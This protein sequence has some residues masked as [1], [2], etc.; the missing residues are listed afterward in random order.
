MTDQKAMAR[1]LL[2]ESAIL[3][4]LTERNKAARKE[5]SKLFEVGDAQT[6]RVGSES[7][8]RVRKDKGRT[9]AVVADRRAFQA[10]IEENLPDEIEE[11][12]ATYRIRPATEK[13]ILDRAKKDGGAFDRATGEEIP[14]VAIRTSDPTLNV[15]A[16]ELAGQVAEALIAALPTDSD[17][18]LSLL[19]SDRPELVPVL[20]AELVDEQ[21][22]S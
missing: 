16:E 22:A 10:W 7:L 12:P 21:Q 9:S 3:A 5:A 19:S 1:R 17:V 6:A 13:A 2:L 18:L 11:V 20:D 14:G 4:A 8:G 15:S